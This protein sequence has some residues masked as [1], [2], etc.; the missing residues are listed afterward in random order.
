LDEECERYFARVPPFLGTITHSRAT[1]DP[2]FISLISGILETIAHFPSPGI[3]EA[4]IKAA[5]PPLRQ[6]LGSS[7]TDASWIS[8][9]AL[10]LLTGIVK[11][12]DNERGLGEG[13]FA[14]IAPPLFKCLREA[15]D[16]DVLQVR[17]DGF[18]VVLQILTFL[19]ERGFLFDG[20]HS[21]RCPAGV[22]LDRPEHEPV[23]AG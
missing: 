10:D 4:L 8:S 22:I 18:D 5:L 14:A 16:R 20:Y 7:G 11:G 21:E 3:Y 1:S 12:V 19:V 6:A 15:E 9:S 2:I 17:R 13:F 23:W